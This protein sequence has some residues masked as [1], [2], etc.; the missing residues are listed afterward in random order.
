MV[1]HIVMMADATRRHVGGIF[2]QAGFEGSDPLAHA[3]KQGL[4]SIELCFVGFAVTEVVA[5]YI[6]RKVGQLIDQHLPHG[7]VPIVGLLAVNVRLH[8]N[9]GE[10]AKACLLIHFRGN[11]GPYVAV[12]TPTV[13]PPGQNCACL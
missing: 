10:Y 8:L 7:S 5:V 12:R 13:F 9:D 3:A 4:A 11:E 6:C 2:P 1:S